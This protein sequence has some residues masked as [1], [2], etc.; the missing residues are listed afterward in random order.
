[1]TVAEKRVPFTG[2]FTT[3][4]AGSSSTAREVRGYVGAL[5]VAAQQFPTVL[6]EASILVEGDN[7]GAIA[8]LNNLRSPVTEINEVLKNVF[9][10]CAEFK[11][12]IIGKWI[13][14]NQLT[15]ADALSREPDASDWGISRRVLLDACRALKV[16]PSVDIFASDAHHTTAK[17]ISQFFTPGCQAVDATRIDWSVAVPKG[18][19]AWIF[20]PNKYVSTAKSMIER[21]QIDALICFSVRLGSNEL[22]QLHQI[23]GADVSSPFPIPRSAESCTPSCRVPSAS[24]NPAFL[25]LGIFRITWVHPE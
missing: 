3:E 22:I 8:A 19:V 14:R 13:P 17:F 24:L 9:E 20:P 23:K 11:T 5:V 15:E 4:Q 2:T 16:E 6:K 1:M 25:E 21:Y 12:D 10:L 7:Q 18:E